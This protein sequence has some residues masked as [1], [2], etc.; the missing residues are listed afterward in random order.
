MTKNTV[1]NTKEPSTTSYKVKAR[2]SQ[3]SGPPPQGTDYTDAEWKTI[4]A[5]WVALSHRTRLSGSAS[6]TTARKAFCEHY[7]RT[8][9]TITTKGRALGLIAPSVPRAP[10]KENA[11]GTIPPPPG[12]HGRIAIGNKGPGAPVSMANDL[13]D[14]QLTAS[15]HSTMGEERRELYRLRKI[16]HKAVEKGVISSDELENT[17][18]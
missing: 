1:N 10:L 7:Q 3:G 5:E 9:I 17:V 15:V 6:L 14:R 2:Q 12:M 4:I 16:V 11:R 18:E 8:Y 13:K